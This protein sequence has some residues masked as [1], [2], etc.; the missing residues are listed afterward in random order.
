MKRNV[1]CAIVLATLL[2]SAAFA[3]PP[4]T[5][6]K[7]NDFWVTPNNNQTKFQFKDGDVEHLCGLPPSST[8]DH[9]V[10][11]KGV[12]ATGSDYDTVVARLDNAV[13]DTTGQAS[14][15]VQV[16]LLNLVSAAP[17]STPCGILNWTVVLAGPQA[18]T[19]MKLRK[20]TAQGGFFSADIAVNVEL[21]ATRNGVY[22]GSVFYNIVLPDPMT[23]TPWSIGPTGQFRAGM[24]EANDCIDV[25]RQK[26]LTYP[27][28]SD[29][30]Y[31]I[32][33]MIAKGQCR[34]TG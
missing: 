14:T 7:G 19:T 34:Q 9:H 8:W 16:Q 13:F 22:L 5:I 3:V 30:F 33:D 31:Y 4:F 23:G 28:D 18:V 17:Q 12:P 10:F 27:Q 25:L 1:L 11:L 26:L 2:A 15:R 20:T 21:R 29:H 32:S 24:T 6:I